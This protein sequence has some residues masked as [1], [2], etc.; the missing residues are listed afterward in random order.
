[1]WEA[2]S[3]SNTLTS[4]PDIRYVASFR[5]NFSLS[6]LITTKTNTTFLC[7]P[8]VCLTW[9]WAISALSLHSLGHSPGP[10]AVPLQHR[11]ALLC[12]LAQPSFQSTHP[13]PL[14]HHL[15]HSMFDVT[16]SRMPP[17]LPTLSLRQVPLLSS[18]QLPFSPPLQ[19]VVGATSVPYQTLK[20]RRAAHAGFTHPRT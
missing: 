3:P 13:L 19:P 10:W 9:A 17:Y 12:A 20:H 1:M 7:V 14:N 18:P 2:S 6:L 4:V 15:V 8:E 16:S 11:A 5:T